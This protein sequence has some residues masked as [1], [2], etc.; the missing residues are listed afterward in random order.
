MLKYLFGAL[1][2]IGLA[3]AA[4]AEDAKPA[5]ALQGAFSK[6]AGDFEVTWKF[7]KAGKGTFEIVNTNNDGLKMDFSYTLKAGKV[8]IVIDKSEKVGEFPT[9]PDKGA[10]FGFSAALKGKD[11]VL[12]D[13]TGE[14]TDE[15]KPIVEGEYKPK[16]KRD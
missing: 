9:V 5:D 6:D 13:L 8:E 10:K 3:A 15:A 4:R 11:L 7:Q 14:G 16:K 2:L 12:S 1:A